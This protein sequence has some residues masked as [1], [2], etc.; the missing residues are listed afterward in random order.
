MIAYIDS[1]ALLRILLNQEGKVEEFTRVEKAVSSVLMR[2]ECLRTL[3]RLK[4][5]GKLTEN[6]YVQVTRE[7]Y[8]CCASIEFIRLTQGILN[9]A[10]APMPVSIG[11]LDAIHL[12]S[13][14]AWSEQF[15]V[16]PSFFTHDE[17]LG[18]AAL[19]FGLPVVGCKF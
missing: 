1:S 17:Q 11:T 15:H 3:D 14:L 2:T 8:A 9:R 10:A 12:S 4:L 5:Q 6:S 18:K 7:F 13:A 19:S 16:L